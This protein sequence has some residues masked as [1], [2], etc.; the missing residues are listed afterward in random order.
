MTLDPK[1]GGISGYVRS[2]SQTGDYGQ[3]FASKLQNGMY[4]ITNG[5][6]RVAALKQLGYRYIN[7]F[8]V[9]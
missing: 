9:P 8:L 1:D 2:I 7:F 3:I 4:Q 5:R 6:H